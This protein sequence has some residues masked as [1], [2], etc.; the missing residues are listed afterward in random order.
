MLKEIEFLGKN[1]EKALEKASDELNLPI[2]KIKHEVL[3]Y[4]STGIFGLVGVKKAKI[5]VFVEI[6]EKRVNKFIEEKERPTDDYKK[7]QYSESEKESSIDTDVNL[8]YGKHALKTIVDA[9][10][11]NAEIDAKK[12][13]DKYLFEISAGDSGVLIGKRGQTLEAIQY[14]LEKMINKKS[15]NRLRVMVDIEGYLDKRKNNL[16]QMAQRM[17]EK[18][19]RIKKPVTIGQMN[20]HDRRIVHIHLKDEQGIRTQSVGEGYY[21]K[22]MIFPKKQGNRRPRKEK[23]TE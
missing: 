14:L 20:A 13:G 3:T 12:K 1:V 4:G 5:K 11:D 8:D 10:S 7:L 17:A 15:R 21:R 2:N 22:L 18:A 9:I 6:E 16:K 23:N 19:K